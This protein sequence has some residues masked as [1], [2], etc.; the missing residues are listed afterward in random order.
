MNIVDCEY[1]DIFVLYLSLVYLLYI[2]FL[3]LTVYS[4]IVFL[5]PLCLVVNLIL[6]LEMK[7]GISHLELRITFF[8]S[9]SNFYIHTSK[10]HNFLHIQ[11]LYEIQTFLLCLVY[12]S[13]GYAIH[14]H[15]LH[16]QHILCT[17]SN[18]I[19]TNNLIGISSKESRSIGTPCQACTI[20]CQCCFTKFTLKGCWT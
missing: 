11:S 18:R 20:R 5:F 10:N 6:L 7:I 17:N 19:D 13:N 2:S 1:R 16:P 8:K 14:Y 4:F 12:T 15:H 3:L 9:C